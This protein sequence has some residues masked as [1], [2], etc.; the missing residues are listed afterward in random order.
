VATLSNLAER[1]RVELGDIA[2][3][4]V[5]QFMADGTTNRFELNHAPL[6]GE[7]IIVLKDGV[8]ISD[9]CSVEESSGTLVTDVLPSDGQTLLVNGIYYRYFTAQEMYQ[10]VETAL[11]QHSASRTDSMGQKLTVSNLPVLEEY[12]VVIY[13]V[14]LALYTLATDASFDINIFA[15]D[16][17]TIPRSERYRQLMEMIENR[18]QQYKELC[19][20]LGIGLYSIEVFSFKRISKRTNRYVPVYKP[21]EVDDRSYPQR[22]DMPI[23]TYGDKPIAWPT[24]GGELLAY[25]GRSFSASIDF[26]AADLA[27]TP[28]EPEFVGRLLRQRGS[29][30]VAQNF[31]LVVVDNEDGTFTATISL[32]KDQTLRLARRTYWSI[33][34]VDDTAEYDFYEIKGGNFFTEK[35]SE[36]IV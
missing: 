8:D 24:T 9:E 28:A 26:T 35:V 2:K 13:A 34:V 15:P 29:N 5:E 21:Q 23:P 25:Q 22:V 27:D 18:K 11:L 30:Q 16:G 12:P 31:T 33:A 36:V 19:M 3:S 4:F 10:I 7:S 14:T 6:D 20:L 17:V 32:S 1:V